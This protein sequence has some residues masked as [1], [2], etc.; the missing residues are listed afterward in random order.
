MRLNV[1]SAVGAISIILPLE[2]KQIV[3]NADHDREQYYKTNPQKK[4][5]VRTR[6]T[7]FAAAHPGKMGDALYTLPFIRHIYR[8]TGTQFDFY[9]SDYCAPLKELFEY[10][11]CIDQVIIPE[12]YRV[13]RMDMGC[14]PWQMPIPDGYDKVYQLGFQRIPDRAIHQFI[15]HEQGVDIPLAVE[16]DYPELDLS[17]YHNYICIAPRGETTFKQLFNGVAQH[18]NS[19]IIGSTD[20]Y[21][22][23]GFDVTGKNMLDTL[24]ILAGADGFLG[25]MSSQLVLANGFGYPKV[26]PHDGHS[27]D[28]GHVI[29]QAS[30]HYP[31]NPSVEQV[32]QLLR[33]A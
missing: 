1:R 14:Q 27:W 13:E 23:F 24:T 26:A 29:K 17:P 2:Q 30:N 15:A 10:Q 4:K 21:T 5:K 3:P 8:E 16:Y 28:M 18:T 25:L 6:M 33:G 9:T 32:V 20:D 19:V 12:N 7:K 31:I 11:D 22:G